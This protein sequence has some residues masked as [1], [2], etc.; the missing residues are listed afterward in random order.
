MEEHQLLLLNAAAAGLDSSVTA[1]GYMYVLG[2]LYMWP[3]NVQQRRLDVTLVQCN[4]WQA[5]QGGAWKEEPALQFLFSLLA[6]AEVEAWLEGLLLGLALAG[7]AGQCWLS[8]ECPAP[9]LSRLYCRLR[10]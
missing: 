8:Q 1:A 3:Q 10:R 5:G 7:P 2:C 4:P 6:A 9:L